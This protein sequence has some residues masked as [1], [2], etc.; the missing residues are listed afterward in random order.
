[1]NLRKDHYRDE[2]ERTPRE[3]SAGGGGWRRPPRFSPPTARSR[4]RIDEREWL[5][6]RLFGAA[7]DPRTRRPARGRACPLRFAG[8]PD[9]R[10]PGRSPPPPPPRGLLRPAAVLERRRTGE[11]RRGG[12]VWGGPAPGARSG[13]PG[14]LRGAD[15]GAAGRKNGSP[16]CRGES[17][18]AARETGRRRETSPRAG[19]PVGGGRRDLDS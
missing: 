9:P 19:A 3:E 1:V 15:R 10:S 8:S 18:G 4:E 13:P 7:E 6:G 17:E 14:R 16:V 5:P 12:G 2:T 11:S